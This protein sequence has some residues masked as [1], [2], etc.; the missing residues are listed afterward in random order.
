[1]IFKRWSPIHAMV[2]LFLAVPVVGGESD[3][4]K[5]HQVEINKNL[6]RMVRDKVWVQAMAFK[7]D[8]KQL[9]IGITINSLRIVDVE[10]GETWKML[11]SP[12]GVV[13]NKVTLSA[14]SPDGKTLAVFWDTKLP[15]RQDYTISIYDA[16]TLDPICDCGSFA[17]PPEQLQ[18]PTQ[19]SLLLKFA[20]NPNEAAFP[21]PHCALVDVK[22]GAVT[23]LARTIA[24]TK[25]LIVAAGANGDFAISADQALQLIEGKSQKELDARKFDSTI[26]GLGFSPDGKTLLIETTNAIQQYEVASKKLKPVLTKLASERGNWSCAYG[27][28]AG[29]VV[30]KVSDKLRLIDIK[31]G[32]T[33]TTGAQQFS[34]EGKFAL[35]P[36]GKQLALSETGTSVELWTIGDASK[37]QIAAV[38]QKPKPI[39]RIWTTDAGIFEAELVKYGEKG[40]AFKRKNNPAVLLMSLEMLSPADRD[41]IRRLPKQ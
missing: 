12:K 5:L 21:G 4:N 29:S 8:S 38:E 26:L 36:D 39:V 14:W 9:A 35:A 19:E 40:V 33:L 31:N 13:D 3:F 28:A 20:Q 2:L 37:Q 11:K 6:V 22:N 32:K 18:W 23:Q 41:F 17:T 10:T 1:M 16:E 7:P 34:S 24:G 27:P 15:K 25:S 30:G